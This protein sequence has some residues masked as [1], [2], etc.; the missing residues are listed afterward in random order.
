MLNKDLTQFDIKEGRVS[1]EIKKAQIHWQD[2]KLS[3]LVRLTQNGNFILLDKT[4]TNKLKFSYLDIEIGKADLE[5]ETEGLLE[6]QD[7]LFILSWS[8]QNRI[9]RLYINGTL[10]G[11]QQIVSIEQ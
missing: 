9:I 1:F 2:S 5:I 8:A 3:R 6:N 10:K 11:T 4:E 7:Y